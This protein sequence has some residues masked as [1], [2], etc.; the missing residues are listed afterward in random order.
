[1]WSS[2]RSVDSVQQFR[3]QRVDQPRVFTRHQY[4]MDSVGYGGL[5]STQ[6]IRLAVASTYQPPIPCSPSRLGQRLAQRA[7]HLADMLRDRGAKAAANNSLNGKPPSN[8]ANRL[9][10]FI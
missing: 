1:M 4:C 5:R 2:V 6:S 8:L 7:D 9:T 10:E 3:S